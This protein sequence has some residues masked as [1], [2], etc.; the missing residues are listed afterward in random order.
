MK[1]LGIV[2]IVV[3]IIYSRVK[4]KYNTTQIKPDIIVG[5]GGV[6][7]FYTMGICHYIR[8]HFN[9]N[10]KNIVGFSSGSWASLLL[11]IKTEHINNLLLDTFIINKHTKINN[12]LNQ[13]KHVI[14][15]KY[16]LSDFNL[17]NTYVAVTHIL[18]NKLFLHNE[19]LSLN[20]F[21]NCCISSS[22]IPCVTYNDCLYFYQN[23]LVIDGGLKYNAYIKE[24][25]KNNPLVIDYKMFGRFSNNSIFSQTIQTKKNY[26]NLYIKGYH[27]ASLNHKYLENHFS[28]S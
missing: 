25:H 20:E 26:Y 22:F 17:N 21:M 13:F 11:T 3:I 10:N 23:N 4:I 27:D 28:I 8:N 24:N 7:G 6:Y 1:Y 16:K 18:K 9:V 19:F 2:V 15:K 5:P 12:M 14:L